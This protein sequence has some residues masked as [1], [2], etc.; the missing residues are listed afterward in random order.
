MSSSNCSGSHSGYPLSVHNQGWVAG[1]T[2]VNMAHGYISFPDAYTGACRQP[3]FA[4]QSSPKMQLDPPH[5]HPPPQTPLRYPVML[6]CGALNPPP[7][8]T[9]H[10]STSSQSCTLS[11]HHH[12]PS[13]TCARAT[14]SVLDTTLNRKPHTVTNQGLSMSVCLHTLRPP[15]PPHRVLCARLR[16]VPPPPSPPLS[17]TTQNPSLC[18][19]F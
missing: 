16:S 3:S 13:P 4:R 2:V 19:S 12:L 6:P 7:V 11:L 18:P 1:N 14:P 17:R 15:F 9:T 5:T 10:H 8:T